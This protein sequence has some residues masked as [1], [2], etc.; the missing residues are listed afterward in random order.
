MDKS[1]GT[2]KRIYISIAAAAVMFVMLAVT[3]YSLILS[4]LSVEDNLFETAQV[5]LELNNGQTVFNGD[6]MNIEPGHSI[7]RD[8]TVENKSTVEVYYRL[9]LENVSGPLRDTLTFEIYDGS[10]LLFSG[11]ADDMTRESPCVDSNP[12]AAGEV[13]TL[14]AVVKMSESASSE[15][16]TASV[17]FDISADA[18]Q[19]R[20]N[21]DRLFG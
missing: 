1:K 18:V 7:V 14:T 17:S 10:T 5:Q 16:Q 12:L 3:T 2:K 11:R 8:F 19:A 15:Y 20:N 13:R 9:Y 6:D 4:L 21:P